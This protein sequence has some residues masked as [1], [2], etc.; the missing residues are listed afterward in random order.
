MNMRRSR[1]GGQVFSVLFMF[2]VGGLAGG[3]PEGGE[4][5]FLGS[6]L[7][8]KAHD[9]EIRGGLAY[10]AFLDGFQILD[11]SNPGDPET[12]SALHLGGGYAV[13]LAGD[14]ALVAAADKGL[15]VID[16]SDPKAPVLKSLLDTP[17]EARDVTVNGSVVLVADGP[18]GLLA[19]DISN[20][21]APKIVGS[22]DS[23][24]EATG[25]FLRG[26]TVFLADGSAGLQ[27]VDVAAPARL[28]PAGAV[29][30]DGTAES[31]ALSG[32]TAYIADGSGGIKVMDITSTAAP[33]LAASLVASGYARS[34]AVSGKLLG[35]GSLYDGGYQLFDIS[36][37]RSP[38]LVSTN[39][40]TMY[41][42]GWRIVLSES[43]GVVVDYFSGLFF[44]DF[45]DPKKPAAAGFF[46]TPS[47]VVGVCG[48]DRYAFAVGELSGVLVVDVVDPARP[49]LVGAT[50]IFRGVQNIAVNGNFVYVTDRWSIRVFDVADPAKPKAGK[51]LTFTEGIPRTLV[52]RGSSAYLTADNFGFYTLDLTDPA[53][54]KVAGSL[55]LPGFTY[56]LALSGDNAYLANSDTGLHIIDVRKRDAPAEIGVVKLA[57]EPSGV[58]VRGRFAYVASGPEGLI[59][60]D[61]GRPDAPKILGAAASGD[62]SS[63]VVL[64]GDFAYVA[65]GLAG[66]MKIDVSVPDSP[67]LVSSCDTPGE[68]QNLCVLGKN[69]LVADTY[70][71]II[72]K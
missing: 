68:A 52:I 28:S 21:A 25:L 13:S 72:L 39:K 6:S 27:I 70:S 67:R 60:V 50:N 37:P 5:A 35:V 18:G 43:R 17:G 24:G 56:G 49:V 31:V 62:Y 42:E 57:G 29:D 51:P 41:N 12:L 69:I 14:I 11:V 15:A 7:W 38:V 71:L 8:T 46:P 32:N 36:Q 26:Q 23:P 20:P 19:V 10:C 59:A 40:Y 33:R 22:W 58:A 34:V 63:A 16:V 48:R 47:T 2:L 1:P 45:A 61:V 53:A 66:V 44:L 65:D 54:P 30:T 55:R 64:D 3:A 4:L 9:I